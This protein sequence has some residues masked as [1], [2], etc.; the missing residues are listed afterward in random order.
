[1][2][3]FELQTGQLCP[4]AIFL[5]VPYPLRTLSHGMWPSARVA[6]AGSELVIRDDVQHSFRERLDRVDRSCAD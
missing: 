6:G 5:A 4:R 1:M 3:G 2:N